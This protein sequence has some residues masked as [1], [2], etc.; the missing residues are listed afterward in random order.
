[1]TGAKGCFTIDI[2]KDSKQNT[3][4]RVKLVFNICIHKKNEALLKKLRNY[5]GVGIEKKKNRL[6]ID[7]SITSQKDLLTVP[8]LFDKYPLITP[9]PPA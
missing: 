4:W 7:Y 2:S 1:M 6:F 8:A 5:L 9:P 3:G